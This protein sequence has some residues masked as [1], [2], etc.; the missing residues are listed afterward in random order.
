MSP[1]AGGRSGNTRTNR[2]VRCALRTKAEPK[3]KAVEAE[4]EEEE[5][6]EDVG[7]ES[8]CRSELGGDHSICSQCGDVRTG[9]LQLMS[10]SPPSAL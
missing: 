2:R 4:A 3:A 1:S 7:G 10:P 5:N 8:R 6:D 9:E